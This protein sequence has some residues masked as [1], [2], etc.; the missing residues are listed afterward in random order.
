MWKSMTRWMTAG[1]L[2]AGVST[3]PA[4]GCGQD[5]EERDAYDQVRERQHEVMQEPAFQ[6]MMEA[7]QRR[8]QEMR[9]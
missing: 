3:L 2:V 6:Q 1:L 9:E 5:P 8:Q 4:L 7:E